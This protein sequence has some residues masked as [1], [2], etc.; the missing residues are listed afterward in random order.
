MTKP[1]QP[2]LKPGV[3]TDIP[4]DLIDPDPE[5]PRTH[6]N[7]ASLAELAE[8]FTART[9]KGHPPLEQPVKVRPTGDGRFM[10]KV[11]ER[12]WRAAKLA[13]LESLPVLLAEEGDEA[14]APVTRLADQF[15]ENHHR[16]A[17]N[18]LDTARFFKR[19]RD[20]H[21]IK[22]TQMEDTLKAQGITGF[23]RSY[24]SNLIRLLDLPEWAQ[25]LIGEGRLSAAHGKQLLVARDSEPVME[26]TREWIEHELRLGT[27]PT[28][29][30][31][32]EAVFDA[33][34]E[35]HTRL[36]AFGWPLK[37]R[38]KFDLATCDKCK[39]RRKVTNEMGH[40]VAF[41]LD[42]ACFDQKQAEAPEP[43]EPQASP[44]PEAHGPIEV[45]PNSAGVVELFRTDLTLYDD[46]VTPLDDAA[47]DVETVCQACPHRRLTMEFQDD[48]PFEACYNE[49]CYE[50]H[51]QSVGVE[52]ARNARAR[53]A[54][55]GWLKKR[56]V[57]DFLAID[58]T[59]QLNVLAYMALHGNFYDTRR[60]E[61]ASARG[62]EDMRAIVERGAMGHLA[63]IAA[64]GIADM[65]DEQ[66]HYLAKLVGVTLDPQLIRADYLA[67]MS[68]K[69]LASLLME[70]DPERADHWNGQKKADRE[71]FDAELDEQAYLA[72][73]GDPQAFA[74][75]YAEPALERE[76]P[77]GEES[78]E[79]APEAAHA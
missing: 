64:A 67:A 39:T 5:Q 27:N 25:E 40:T 45:E 70:V 13:K 12:R 43:A 35:H 74:D 36:E 15:K 42:R 58:Q 18:A 22:M 29:S 59:L 68:S 56:L 30:E 46:G 51:S 62:L 50:T 65:Q 28:E 26:A 21:K 54:L 44:E 7:M 61:V 34:A 31:I 24:I 55:M 2:T 3:V 47:F 33:Y 60:R 8:D 72:L 17:L 11:G 79:P 9:A 4:L 77:K 14:D 69:D 63:E 75:I 78:S 41:C 53:R 71:L 66:V 49:Q 16:E 57:G 10:L 32:Q 76:A 37:D 73:F 23:S 19:L 20:E 1:K 38:P 6:F 48:D 52:R